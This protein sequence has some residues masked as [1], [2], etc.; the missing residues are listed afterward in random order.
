MLVWFSE[1]WIKIYWEFILYVSIIWFQCFI[2]IMYLVL[3]SL[4]VF[5]NGSLWALYKKNDRYLQ[6]WCQVFSLCVGTYSYSNFYHRHRPTHWDL[7]EIYAN[8][9]ICFP[10]RTNLCEAMMKMSN[11]QFQ[12]SS[13]K[14][15]PSLSRPHCVKQIL[16]GLCT[17]LDPYLDRVFKYWMLFTERF[18]FCYRLYR[19][20]IDGLVQEKRNSI[21]NALELRLSCTNP[22]I[23]L[24]H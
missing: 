5:N 23:Y 14:R 3:S 7:I 16:I 10:T 22:S 13:P 6:I 9:A 20:Y 19:C 24:Y 21:A 2:F 12:M 8:I 15:P 18:F 1:H 17:D 4:N 11:S